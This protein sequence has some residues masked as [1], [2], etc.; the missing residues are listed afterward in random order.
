MCIFYCEISSFFALCSICLINKFFGVIIQ[1]WIVF[2]PSFGK[3]NAVTLKVCILYSSKNVAYVKICFQLSHFHTIRIYSSQPVCLGVEELVTVSSSCSFSS[4]INWAARA[5]YLQY[6]Y[7]YCVELLPL[8]IRGTEKSKKIPHTL[9]SSMYSLWNPPRWCPL[10]QPRNAQVYQPCMLPPWLNFGF[11]HSKDALHHFSLL[12]NERKD[13]C[14]CTYR[15]R[16]LTIIC[17]RNPINSIL[18]R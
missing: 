12:Y 6:E 9:A 2:V 15:G 18:A 5:P 3:Q 8:Q 10:H 11:A 14:I 16:I 17:I 1:L 7:T 4:I 13:T